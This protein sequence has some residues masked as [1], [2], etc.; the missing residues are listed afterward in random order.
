MMVDAICRLWQKIQPNKQMGRRGCRSC[1]HCCELFGGYL[2]AS[3]C[4]IE[5]WR[6]LGRDD[7]LAMV[8]STG[9]IWIHPDR[10][11]R[12]ERCPFLKRLDSD[13]AIC[14]IHDIKPDICRDY[15]SLDHGRHCVRGFYIPRTPSAP[16][17][18]IH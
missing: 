2:H 4:D 9:W 3:S 7:L 12:G 10:S 18:S 13:H 17:Q 5:R 15:P 6:R 11:T 8:N 14:A 1:G 16:K